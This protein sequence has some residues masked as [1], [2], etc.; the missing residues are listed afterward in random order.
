MAQS[1][2]RFFLAEDPSARFPKRPADGKQ[3]AEVDKTRSMI[4]DGTVSVG[5][6]RDQV[7]I[8][9]GYPRADR[10]PSLDAPTWRYWAS[11]GDTFEIYFEGD[12]VS[13]VSRQPPGRGGGRRRGRGEN[14]YAR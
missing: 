14:F 5:M 8:A 4:E 9:L 11:R 7:L 2:G 12:H 10:T 1:S 13:H 3:A 6:T